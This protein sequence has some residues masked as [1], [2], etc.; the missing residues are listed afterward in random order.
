MLPLFV[1]S[2]VALLAT[3]F[4]LF[5]WMTDGRLSDNVLG[6][7]LAGE[8]GLSS[9]LQ[10][11]RIVGLMLQDSAVAAVMVPL[12]IL[13]TAYAMKM[14]DVSIFHL[15]L[16]SAVVVLLVVLADVGAGYN[17]LLDLI[18]LVAILVGALWS[19]VDAPRVL[20]SSAALLGSVLV[21][22]MLASFFVVLKPPVVEALGMTLHHSATSCPRRPLDRFIG[23]NDLVLS[24]D[25]GISALRGERPV[26]LDAF[27]FL[28][29]TERHPEW[30]QDLIERIRSH[31]F[32]VVVLL[33]EIGSSVGISYRQIHFGE[34]V[35]E[36]LMVNYR[37]LAEDDGYFIERG[38]R[39]AGT[40]AGA[41]RG[42]GGRA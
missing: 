32:D 39:V 37:L 18:P 19:R 27:M 20:P 7:A 21:V 9:I 28:R 11:R 25:P 42:E 15:A 34:P 38:G 40:S 1:G 3:E 14:R 2:F 4:L 29:L 6:L 12:A 5:Q 13:E 41:R 30:G 35:V 33:Q 17:H 36:A 26:V 8:S 23:R 22:S 16:G 24:E 31:E 10:S